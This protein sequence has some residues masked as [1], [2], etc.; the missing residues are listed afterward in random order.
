MQWVPGNVGLMVHGASLPVLLIK[1]RLM[2]SML[3][4]K[5]ARLGKYL[6]PKEKLGTSS[7]LDDS[8]LG[9][10]AIM[11][12]RQKTQGRKT[13]SNQEIAAQNTQFLKKTIEMTNYEMLQTILISI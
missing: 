11:F 12:C 7:Q 5:V 9:K 3:M 10:I 2:K 6:N 1:P 4:R 13:G 8:F